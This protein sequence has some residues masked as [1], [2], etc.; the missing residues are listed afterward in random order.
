MRAFLLKAWLI[1]S[2]LAILAY[3]QAAEPLLRNRDI[4]ELLKA[5]VPERVILAKIRT[6]DADFDTSADA[7]I[8]LH[9]NGATEAILDAMLAKRPAVAVPTPRSETAPPAET[10][11]I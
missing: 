7:I 4:S 9:R 2:L 11:P 6:S 10:I 1:G 3:G 5:N 8:A